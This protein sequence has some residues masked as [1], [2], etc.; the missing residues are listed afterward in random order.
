MPNPG[1][2]TEQERRQRENEEAAAAVLAHSFVRSRTS[3]QSD[4]SDRPNSLEV[5]IL[6]GSDADIEDINDGAAVSSLALTRYLSS[7]WDYAL[8]IGL[9][10]ACIVFAMI[11]VMVIPI[12]AKFAFAVGVAAAFSGPALPF[13]I[14][15]VA[16]LALAVTCG[17]LAVH[18]FEKHFP[19]QKQKIQKPTK[20]KRT[21]A[22]IAVKSSSTSIADSNKE[23]ELRNQAQSDAAPQD[24]STAAGPPNDASI[25]SDPESKTIQ[26]DT[27][28]L[29]RQHVLLQVE[30]ELQSVQEDL[31]LQRRYLA[32]THAKHREE[33]R[34]N[35]NLQQSIS[36]TKQEL[37]IIRQDVRIKQQEVS[38]I[39]NE[40]NTLA[41]LEELKAKIH[42][43][44][45][46]AKEE[47]GDGI[48]SIDPS[49]LM[50]DTQKILEITA[51]I[52][53]KVRGQ[54][55]KIKE[56]E[57]KRL[58]LLNKKAM[59]EEERASLERIIQEQKQVYNVNDGFID[60]RLQ[61]L[62]EQR[63]NLTKKIIEIHRY[64]IRLTSGREV[65]Y[66]KLLE[67]AKRK[68][69]SDPLAR[70]KLM[71]Q[72]IENIS[73][74]TETIDV[75]RK[76]NQSGILIQQAEISNIRSQIKILQEKKESLKEIQI[77]GQLEILNT[78]E[79][80]QKIFIL[81]ELML[82]AEE[83]RYLNDFWREDNQQQVFSDITCFPTLLHHIQSSLRLRSGVIDK[84]LEAQDGDMRL[85]IANQTLAD[86][87]SNPAIPAEVK[88]E[89][90]KKYCHFLLDTIIAPLYQCHASKNWLGDFAEG[91]PEH[92]DKMHLARALA[93]VYGLLRQ[94]NDS[95]FEKE[96]F[97]QGSELC[98]SLS[99]DRLNRK[100]RLTFCN[101]FEY[102]LACMPQLEP[103]VMK[104]QESMEESASRLQR[105][106]VQLHNGL[107]LE[108]N[109]PSIYSPMQQNYTQALLSCAPALRLAV[110]KHVSACLEIPSTIPQGHDLLRNAKLAIKE[111]TDGLALTGVM[112]TIYMSQPKMCMDETQCNPVQEKNIEKAYADLMQSVDVCNSVSKISM[113]Y[114]QQQS[115]QWLKIYKL[116]SQLPFRVNSL[117]DAI[118]VRN[119]NV[120]AEENPEHVLA[121][122]V[123]N[124][125]KQ[126]A[127]HALQAF[128]SAIRLL[129]TKTEYGSVPFDE[130][131]TLNEQLENLPMQY[132]RNTI[133]SISAFNAQNTKMISYKTLAKQ[134]R[135]IHQSL[136]VLL[137]NRDESNIQPDTQP[138][139]GVLVMHRPKKK[140]TSRVQSGKNAEFQGMVSEGMEVKLHHLFI[141]IEKRM[142]ALVTFSQDNAQLEKAYSDM[143]EALKR[144]RKTHV[145]EQMDV[146][147]FDA[148]DL[149][150]QQNQSMIELH[151][152]SEKKL[153]VGCP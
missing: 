81:N 144:L 50:R 17:F 74:V 116:I 138:R 70:F 22:P 19:I 36:D 28:I 27:E 108:F 135:A 104:F 5:A 132:A 52:E 8:A 131:K 25:S 44:L 15:G 73:T 111:L 6:I 140:T 79:S 88:K 40:L 68:E 118:E 137:R 34:E 51:Y 33:L 91:T 86:L 97:K 126:K 136:E 145:S 62:E 82:T 105:D 121:L 127:E 24:D 83:T 76:E 49:E 71:D 65:N 109:Q 66:F 63:D 92:W 110:T 133:I 21:D 41:Y 10:G 32:E 114:T 54:D 7:S 30:Q 55:E 124:R 99:A 94:I 115:V 101:S 128:E 123:V 120:S 59:L 89:E 141:T 47:N 103:Y 75:T 98:L 46:A 129:L 16:C 42:N 13:V 130:R 77:Q 142:D 60:F 37:K 67:A 4:F 85:R 122:H 152:P 39:H 29:R 90:A 23:D 84:T 26:I 119:K 72:W 78:L 53:R 38:E 64:C 9:L 95:E 2:E 107:M 61:T 100:S 58:R 113:G 87:F 153:G 56:L 35:N 139:G 1:A 18:Y 112:S 151:K 45:R 14:A 117:H 150:L 148:L 80:D 96:L 11:G 147:V 69:N 149:F 93:V 48:S 125:L 3:S 31:A 106:M 43:H 102:Y 57:G 143:D 20:R 134:W 12:V 146:S